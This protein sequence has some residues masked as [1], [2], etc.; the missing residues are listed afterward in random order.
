MFIFI[1]FKLKQSDSMWK[2]T[3][4]GG[5]MKP[6]FIEIFLAWADKLGRQIL[7]HLGFLRHPFWYSGSL[8]HIFH[9]ST[10]VST[11]TKPLYPH[12]KYLFGIG[13]WIWAE[14][15]WGFS[16]RV[17]AV[18]VEI[19]ILDNHTHSHAFLTLKSLLWWFGTG[20]NYETLSAKVQTF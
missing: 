16:L 15:K 4:Y 18:R 8:V 9:Y 20:N 11:K 12:P 5:P 14:N 13:I 6:F 2:I 7:G 3:D 10:I 17:S 19:N 1:A